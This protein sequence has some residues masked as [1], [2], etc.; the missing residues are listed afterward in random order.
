MPWCQKRKIDKA[1]VDT[2]NYVEPSSWWTR[3]LVAWTCQQLWI[4]TK[5]LEYIKIRVDLCSGIKDFLLLWRKSYGFNIPEHFSHILDRACSSSVEIIESYM[6]P[7]ISIE[8]LSRPYGIKRR[9]LRRRGFKEAVLNVFHLP[10]LSASSAIERLQRISNQIQTCSTP[11]N[12]GLA[13]S[14]ARGVYSEV[15]CS[16]GHGCNSGNHCPRCQRG[17]PSHYCQ[18]HRDGSA[19]GP[20]SERHVPFRV[21]DLGD[22]NSHLHSL[23]YVLLRYEAKYLPR[24]WGQQHVTFPGLLLHDLAKGRFEARG[25]VVYFVHCYPFVHVKSGALVACLQSHHFAHL[26]HTKT[27]NIAPWRCVNSE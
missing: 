13:A 1:N 26:Q 2:S 18:V 19:F 7:S 10:G 11:A 14:Y 20:C 4:E 6:E 23:P 21:K 22:H 16:C 3:A 8:I 5:E 9:N 24:W 17:S 15:D 27:T 12:L 25:V